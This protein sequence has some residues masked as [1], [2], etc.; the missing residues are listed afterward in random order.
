M[1]IQLNSPDSFGL[2]EITKVQHEGDFTL[3]NM[4]GII[5]RY[6]FVKLTHEYEH[7]SEEMHGGKISGRSYGTVES[8]EVWPRA[9]H[10]YENR[11]GHCSTGVGTGARKPAD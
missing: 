5:E 11:V 10:R 3:V 8:T 1:A 7:V 6:G 9:A 4:Q 2:L